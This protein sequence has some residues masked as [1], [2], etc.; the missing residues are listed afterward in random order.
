MVEFINYQGKKYPIRISYYV[1]EMAS[2]E[3]GLGL[4]EVSQN[5]SA[6]KDVLWYALIAGHRMSKKDLS[7]KREDCVWIL[8]EC[9]IDYQKA[10]YKFGQSIV[11]M[12]EELL[13]EKA[14]KKK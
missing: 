13:K 10:L 2:K 4:D 6:Q 11:D 3:L 14:D 12:Q 5:I 1:L 8:D 7:L 9:Y